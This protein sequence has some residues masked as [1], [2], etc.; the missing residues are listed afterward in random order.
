MICAT[1]RPQPIPFYGEL[2][3]VNPMLLL[4]AAMEAR[5][6][7]DRQAGWIGSLTMGA[8]QFCTN[9][10]VAV[11]LEGPVYGDVRLRGR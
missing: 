10:G 9:P 3:S 4:P 7:R 11:A 5:A 8:G 6:A 1:A 2:G